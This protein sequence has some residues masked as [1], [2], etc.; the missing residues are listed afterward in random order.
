[1]RDN[2]KNEPTNGELAIMLENINKS[3]V[4]LHKKADYT[5]GQ[6]KTNTEYRLKQEGVFG[7][8]KMIGIGNVIG[9]IVLYVDKFLK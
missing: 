3:M 6:V 2:M 1:M 4:D 8:F 7:L 5:N 9:L